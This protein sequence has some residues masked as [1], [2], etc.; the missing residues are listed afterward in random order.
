[1]ALFSDRRTVLAFQ[2]TGFFLALSG[3]TGD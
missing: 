3:F 1:L 2:V